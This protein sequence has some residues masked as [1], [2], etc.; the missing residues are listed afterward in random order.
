MPSVLR[1]CPFIVHPHLW[2]IRLI[3]SIKNNHLVT[4]GKKVSDSTVWKNGQDWLFSP[5]ENRK[6]RTN[7]TLNNY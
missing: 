5:W 4:D 7:E 6:Y 3:Q 2:G 1:Q